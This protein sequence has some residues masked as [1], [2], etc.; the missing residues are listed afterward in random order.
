MRCENYFPIGNLPFVQI[1]RD[2]TSLYVESTTMFE[3]VVGNSSSALEQ[4]G[5]AWM[6]SMT[7]AFYGN[8]QR[9]LTIVIF[10]SAKWPSANKFLGHAKRSSF[11]RKATA[12]LHDTKYKV[13]VAK[14]VD[15]YCTPA[16]VKICLQIWRGRFICYQ[17]S[18][19]ET[20]RGS[21]A[22]VLFIFIY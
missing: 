16:T 15:K 8:Y 5:R 10:Y 17:L 14:C 22:A 18:V 2:V 9:K 6:A 4:K 1:I 20:K 3:C 19:T 21:D 7:L 11:V 12:A 13:H